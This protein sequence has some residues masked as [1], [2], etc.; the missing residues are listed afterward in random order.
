MI[1][2][3][4]VAGGR[5]WLFKVVFLNVMGSFAWGLASGTLQGFYCGPYENP[6]KGGMSTL[7]LCI[8]SLWIWHGFLHRAYTIIVPHSQ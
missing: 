1:L 8:V 3:I 7:R 2:V 5:R 4:R 6:Y